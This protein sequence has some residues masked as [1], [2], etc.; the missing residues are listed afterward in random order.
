MNL[1]IIP[2]LLPFLVAQRGLDYAAAAGLVFA[3]SFL[4][5][6]LQPLLGLVTDR[7]QWP[8]MMSLGIFMSGFG[9][10]AIGFM[11]S[12]WAIFTVVLITGL[13][14]A[15]YH[16]EGGRMANCVAGEKK[17]NGMSIFAAGG[18]LGFFVGPIIATLSVTAWGLRGTSVVMIPIVAVVI[19]FAVLHKNFVRMSEAARAEVRKKVTVSG[20]KDDWGAM[21]RLIFPL[22]ARSIVSNG[23]TTFIPLYFVS[24]L[25]TTQ[26]RGSIMVTVI[27]ISATITTFAGGWLADR[28]GLRRIVRI[29]FVSLAPLI[30]LVSLTDSVWIATALIVPLAFTLGLGLGPMVALGQQYLPN[31]VGLSSGI[32]LGIVVGVGGMISPIFGSIGDLYGLTVVLYILA[33]IAAMGLLGTL[34]LKKPQT[35]MQEQEPTVSAE[36][37]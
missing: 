21:I 10:A 36:Q 33:G 6:W 16:P 20:L 15:I 14:S 29:S 24:V 4:S 26:P 37:E 2:A 7:K 19:T 27:S 3:G 23:M 5:S 32:I 11:E 13:G 30:I 28:F 25:M 22:V 31:R 34:L 9:I 1:A 12:Y 8:W 17:G 35:H 18:N